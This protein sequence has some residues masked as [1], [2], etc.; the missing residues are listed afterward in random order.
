[1]TTNYDRRPIVPADAW[2]TDDTGG[3]VGIEIANAGQQKTY[4]VS[5]DSPGTGATFDDATIT[6]ATITT[7]GITTANVATLNVTGTANLFNPIGFFGNLSTVVAGTPALAMAENSQ[8]VMYSPF[9]V[10]NAGG[11]AISGEMRVYS[12]PV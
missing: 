12:W 8:M 11:V 10:Q 9:T 6:T 7:A 5:T 2:L 1:M 3:I 4:L